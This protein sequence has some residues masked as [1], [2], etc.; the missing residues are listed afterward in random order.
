MERLHRLLASATGRR[1]ATVLAGVLLLVQ[2]AAAGHLHLAVPD[3]DRGSPHAFCD[4]CAA[5]DRSAVAPPSVSIDT[6]F[7]AAGALAPTALAGPPAAPAP[8]AYSSRAPPLP[9]A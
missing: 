1:F 7:V 4:L 3:S 5:T 9:L 6:P 2:L 8:G